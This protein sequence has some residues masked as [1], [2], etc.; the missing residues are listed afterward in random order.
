MDYYVFDYLKQNKSD[1]ECINECIN[2]AI[3]DNMHKRIIFNRHDWQIDEAILL[4]DDMEVIID[5]CSI[6]QNDYVFDNIF[7][8]ANLK[9]NEEDPYGKPLYITK[10]RN[11]TIK[12][13]NKGRIIG[14]DKNKR[15]YHPVTEKEEDMVGDFWGWRTISICLSNCEDIEICGLDILQTKC[16]AISL[17]VCSYGNLHDINIV[18]DVKNGD[19]I[20]LRAGCHH[21][22]IWNIYG[23]TSDDTVA[24]TALLHS[25]K[26]FP[27]KK[28]L[29]PLEPMISIFNGDIRDLDIHDISI[30]D[31]HTGG[32]CHGVI[33]LAADGLRTYNINI[34]DIE[35]VSKGNRTSTV[36]LYTGY[37]DNY[38][39]NDLHDIS[40]SGI[41]SRFSKY[42]VY[43]NTKVD[44]VII[45]DMIQDNPEGSQFEFAYPEGI[46]VNN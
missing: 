30:T 25:K 7:R 27:F 18:S 46:T 34:K 17:D 43:I 3:Q 23:N 39:E 26:Q 13:Y 35:D 38:T 44:N 14:C 8:G 21:F 5:G 37:G 9:V 16:W 32:L 19:G 11:I 15:G 31:I 28:Y 41:H 45:S 33:C 1:S 42:A 24:C 20:D 12:G 4:Y 40:I 22:R 6:K 29:Y 36:M 2:H 10:L